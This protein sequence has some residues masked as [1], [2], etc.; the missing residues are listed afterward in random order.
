MDSPCGCRRR[1]APRP[2]IEHIKYIHTRTVTKEFGEIVGESAK[3]GHKNWDPKLFFLGPKNGE[4]RSGRRHYR[5][6]G[7]ATNKLV[8][9][10]QEEDSL[11]DQIFGVHQ[12]L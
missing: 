7:D 11:T 5:T 4:L 10:L 2:A 8:H 6:S 9:W 12:Y 1:R 3:R